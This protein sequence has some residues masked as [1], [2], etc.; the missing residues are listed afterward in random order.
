MLQEVDQ[1]LHSA[2]NRSATHAIASVG[3]G[4]WAHAVVAH[5]KSS[6]PPAAV[7]TVEPKAACCLTTSLSAGKVVPIKTGETIMNGMNCGT[8]SLIAWPFLRDGVDASIM[9]SEIEG[10]EAVLYLKKHGVEAGPCGAAPLAALKK[11]KGMGWFDLDPES[12]VVLFCTE[13]SREYQVPASG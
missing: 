6:Q 3:V 2:I 9:V 8:V 7:A 1:Q 4:S 5:Y 11:L 12:T 10:H 13:G